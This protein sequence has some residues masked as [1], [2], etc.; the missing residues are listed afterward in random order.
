MKIGIVITMYDESSIVIHT[1]QQIKAHFE[2]S[3]IVLVHSDNNE[4]SAAL[5]VI[6]EISSEYIKLPDM[7]KQIVLGNVNPIIIRNFNIGFNSLYKLSNE[8]DLV[9][10]MTGDTLIHDSRSFSRR[11]MEMKNNQWI[12]M[13]SQAVGQY[14]HTTAADGSRIVEGRYQ[15]EKTTDFACCIF[16]LDG[17]WASE[18]KAFTDIEITNIWT[19]E[20]CLGDEVI[21]HLGNKDFHEYVGRLNSS[22]PTVAYSYSDGTQYHAKH[23]GIPAGRH[24]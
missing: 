1:M 11:Y 10:A 14:F 12:A 4:K 20:Q 9:V 21:K 6:K 7:S 17:K 15:S 24:L 23:G 8:Y 3:E 18:H 13:V 19:N 2:D 5:D 22:N 16:F